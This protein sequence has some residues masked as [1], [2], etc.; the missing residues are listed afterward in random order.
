MRKSP[1]LAPLESQKPAQQIA[2][3]LAQQPEKVIEYNSERRSHVTH[4]VQYRVRPIDNNAVEHR[5]WAWLWECAG[6]ALPRRLCQ[7][8]AWQAWIVGENEEETVNKL[9]FSAL[10]GGGISA[11][12]ECLLWTRCFFQNA[13]CVLSVFCLLEGLSMRYSDLYSAKK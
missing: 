10:E 5:F 8:D 2:S 1:F 11:A 9:L 6:M 13:I 4:M 3:S 7:P 12:V